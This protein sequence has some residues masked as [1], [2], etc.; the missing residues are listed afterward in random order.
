MKRDGGIAGVGAFIKLGLGLPLPG[1]DCC[2]RRWGR[3]LQVEM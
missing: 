3:E 1:G 2:K